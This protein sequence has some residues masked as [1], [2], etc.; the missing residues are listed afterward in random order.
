LGLGG[1][2]N[3]QKFG[4]IETDKLIANMPATKAMQVELEKMQKTYKDEIT[5]L[6]KKYEE[7][8]KKYG[9][10]EKAQTQETNEKRKVEVQQDRNRLAQAEQFATQEMQKKYQEKLKPILESAQKAIKEVATAKGL[11]YIFD[12]SAGKGLIVFEK[13]VDIYDAVKVKLGF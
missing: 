12:A 10:E 6:A 3:A 1:V 9:A 2:A 4:H 13:G 11:V 7:K 5:A 8:L